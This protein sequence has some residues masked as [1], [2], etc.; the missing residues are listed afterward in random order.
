MITKQSSSQY[1]MSYPLRDTSVSYQL[2]IFLLDLNHI[3]HITA[4]DIVQFEK[5]HDFCIFYILL[6]IK[7]LLIFFLH[8]IYGLPS[9]LQINID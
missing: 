4:K 3:E 6:S 7:Y 5:L 1:Q 9:K 8:S 2:K